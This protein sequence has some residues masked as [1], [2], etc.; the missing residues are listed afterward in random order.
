M[1][2]RDER[3]PRTNRINFR[4][5]F[6][7]IHQEVVDRNAWIPDSVDERRVCTIFQQPAN[8]IGQQLL[9]GADRRI[10]TTGAVQLV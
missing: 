7:R 2:K 6:D 1:G 4:R 3:M 8:E 9:M 5:F 10:D